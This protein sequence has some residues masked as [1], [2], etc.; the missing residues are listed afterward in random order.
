MVKT[1]KIYESDAKGVLKMWSVDVPHGKRHYNRHSHNAVEIALVLA[2]KGEY[3]TEKKTYPMEKGDVFVFA[4]NEI[5]CITD[6]CSEELSV[7][8]LHFRP[9]YVADAKEAGEGYV[10]FCFAHSEKFEN[11][12]PAEKA[13]FLSHALNMMRAEY[14]QKD[15]E[16][17]VA[18]KAYLD[19][20][21]VELLR[22]HSYYGTAA[23]ESAD[24]RAAIL[25]VYA[26]IDS[27]L[28]EH[29][30]LSELAR[31]ANLSPNY[32]SKIFAQYNGRSLW[33]YVNSKR[34][35][36]ACRLLLDR[37]TGHTVLDVA[38]ECGFNNTVNFNKIFK[39]H[40]G[41]TPKKLREN[42]ELLFLQ[43]I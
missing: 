15:R 33:D 13:G 11:R 30:S 35:E 14:T 39:K 41:I 27:H 21:L 31:I 17:S 29:L 40:T 25:S 24:R 16:F 36:K 7:V 38:L 2:G 34:I 8:N 42:P 9:E 12:I 4:T 5:H 19:L 43:D 23:G 3:T 20:I 6:V 10:N 1:H 32:F 18:S 26:Y 37:S 22:N 28:A